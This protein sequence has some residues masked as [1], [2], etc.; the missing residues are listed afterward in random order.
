MLVS[1]LGTA[2]VGATV[3]PATSSSDYI[4]T[5]NFARAIA[6]WG[7]AMLILI[8]MFGSKVTSLLVEISIDHKSSSRKDKS[9][10]SEGKQ[11]IDLEKLRE[12]TGGLATIDQ[13]AN[14]FN[15]INMVR[16]FLCNSMLK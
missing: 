15:H 2:L 10:L 9:L 11:N 5:S 16:F 3:L 12:F 7:V 6:V 1:V 8:L 4:S 14:N 13:S